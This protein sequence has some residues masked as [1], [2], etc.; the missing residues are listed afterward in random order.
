MM[1]GWRFEKEI[2]VSEIYGGIRNLGRYIMF[3]N[4]GDILFLWSWLMG[5]GVK[6]INF[7][8]KSI[9]MFLKRRWEL[10]KVVILEKLRILLKYDSVDENV[11]KIWKRNLL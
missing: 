11:N 3:I 9:E 5:I 4:Y 8:F 10:N 1:E 7:I 6:L 2:I